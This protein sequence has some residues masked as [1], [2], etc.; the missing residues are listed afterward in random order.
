MPEFKSLL[1]KAFGFGLAAE[2]AFI[3]TG[4]YLYRKYNSDEGKYCGCKT[5]DS[6]MKTESTKT[7]P[8]FRNKIH[9]DYPEVCDSFKKVGKLYISVLPEDWQ[10]RILDKKPGQSTQS[11]K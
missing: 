5:I 6:M 2:V 7:F 3:G 9:K 10:K 1:K 8:E 4:Y 11:E